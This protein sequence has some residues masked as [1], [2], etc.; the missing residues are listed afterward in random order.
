[1]LL[2][3]LQILASSGPAYVD[4]RNDERWLLTVFIVLWAFSIF[5]IVRYS[6][7][8]WKLSHDEGGAHEISGGSVGS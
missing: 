2:L 3:C 4:W 1:M 5:W 8:L 6:A 7:Q